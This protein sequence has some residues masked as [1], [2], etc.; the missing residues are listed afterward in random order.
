MTDN[1]RAAF[2]PLPLVVTPF[3]NGRKARLVSDFVFADAD[4]DCTY[5][6]QAGESTDWNSTPMVAWSIF[7]P[8]L[9]PEAGLVHD[10]LYRHPQAVVTST[11]ETVTLSRLEC[12]NVHK[13]L[14]EL[15]DAPERL[16]AVAYHALRGPA[17]QIAWDL[18]RRRDAQK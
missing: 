3:D 7:P 11:G 4:A 18:Q 2:F 13:R 12:D 8:W 10:H 9:Y 14:M 15:A 1:E 6:A 17:G 5:R 16:V